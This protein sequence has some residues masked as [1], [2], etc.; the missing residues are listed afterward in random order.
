MN[1]TPMIEIR[2]KEEGKV[3]AVGGYVTIRPEVHLQ[4]P[5]PLAPSLPP[6]GLRNS[7]T[8]IPPRLGCRRVEELQEGGRERGG[9]V[10][11]GLCTPLVHTITLCIW[12][13]HHMTC[14]REVKTRRDPMT[15]SC[16]FTQPHLTLSKPSHVL[17]DDA[18]HG[19]TGIISHPYQRCTG[20]YAGRGPNI[21]SPEGHIKS[22]SGRRMP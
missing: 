5:F 19:K 7:S 14:L 16:N 3:G 6:D 9:G 10:A 18:S 17:G 20:K 4:L 12:F 2:S 1:A 8:L 22:P 13:G 21:T 11:R 15:F